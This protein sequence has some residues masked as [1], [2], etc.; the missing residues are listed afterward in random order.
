MEIIIGKIIILMLFLNCLTFFYRKLF[1]IKT[2]VILCGLFGYVGTEAPNIWK[3]HILG[4]ANQERG[5]DSCGLY[6]NNG[7]VRGVNSDSLYYKMMQKYNFLDHNGVD[8]VAIGHTRSKTVGAATLKNAHPFEIVKYKKENSEDDLEVVLVGAHNG[9]LD[10]HEELA[11]KYKTNI[12]HCEVD[13][14]ALFEILAGGKKNHTVL[15]EYIGAASLLFTNPKYPDTL[16]VW[17]GE[18]RLDDYAK[19]EEEERPL[20]YYE[21]G[22]GFYFSSLEE[23]LFAIGGSKS[24]VHEVPANTLMKIKGIKVTK[25]EYS[26]ANASQKIWFGGSKKFSV[27]NHNKK[28]QEQSV[29]G[30]RTRETIKPKRNITIAG[31]DTSEIIDR[32]L[33][34]INVVNLEK[35]K[36]NILNEKFDHTEIKNNLYFFKNRYHRTG[37]IYKYSGYIY[38][39]MTGEI[40]YCFKDADE[41]TLPETF[42]YNNTTDCKLYYIHNGI[43]F[44]NRSFYLRALETE[45]YDVTKPMTDVNLEHYKIDNYVINPIC[46]ISKGNAS[47]KFLH[48][49]GSATGIYQPPFTYKSYVYNKGNL[50]LVI[51]TRKEGFEKFEMYSPY[52]FEYLGIDVSKVEKE[53]LTNAYTTNQKELFEI[54]GEPVEEKSNLHTGKMLQIYEDEAYYSLTDD[55]YNYAEAKLKSDVNK[56]TSIITLDSLKKTNITIPLYNDLDL[57][58]FIKDNKTG[59]KILR[60]VMEKEVFSETYTDMSKEYVA[61]IKQNLELLDK[62]FKNDE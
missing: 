55:D 54:D 20:F 57:N 29:F 23:S 2:N 35:L 18:S 41:S 49:N 47:F 52:L 59:V 38:L 58:S 7:V 21:T 45:K 33:E 42:K 11:E 56:K 31:M 43:L 60:E 14:H 17:R 4:L 25:T 24:C 53:K 12:K 6:W 50:L 28:K 30:T 37:H 22:T 48:K 39:N 16:Y 9:T 62:L 40:V 19:V 1:K 10:N 5:K 13:S 51:D 8:Y 34:D 44:R 32:L 61:D 36:L 3:L 15:S 46:D 26:R 27:V